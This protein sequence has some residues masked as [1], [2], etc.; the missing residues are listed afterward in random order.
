MAVIH[1]EASIRSAPGKFGIHSQHI[2]DLVY[3]FESTQQYSVVETLAWPSYYIEI[4]N[5]AQYWI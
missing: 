4:G 5:S 1:D 2:Q 3:K